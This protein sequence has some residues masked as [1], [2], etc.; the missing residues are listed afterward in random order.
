MPDDAVTKLLKQSSISFVGTVERLGASTMT[1]V[2]IDNHTAVVRVDQVLHAPDAFVNLAGSPVTVQ[3]AAK[4]ASTPAPAVQ[5]ALAW[6][7]DTRP[8]VCACSPPKA[9]PAAFCNSGTRPISRTTSAR[10]TPA[11]SWRWPK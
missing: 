10:S 2:P 7:S 6:L 9:N 5:P 1:D 8:M 4:P 3:L 11:F